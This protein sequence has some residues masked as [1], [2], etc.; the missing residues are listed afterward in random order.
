MTAPDCPRF[1][2]ATVRRT[3]YRASVWGSR[4]HR[5]RLKCFTMLPRPTQEMSMSG[6]A[7]A[8]WANLEGVAL[9]CASGSGSVFGCRSASVRCN[10][11]YHN[12]WTFVACCDGAVRVVDRWGHWWCVHVIGAFGGDYSLTP[13]D[14]IHRLTCV[15]CWL[16]NEGEVRF[17]AGLVSP[18]CADDTKL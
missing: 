13:N 16:Y 15:L 12:L 10:Y 5:R 4:R 3:S 2:W 1:F 9:R 7:N 17:V 18:H 8:R 14:A 6:D 11:A